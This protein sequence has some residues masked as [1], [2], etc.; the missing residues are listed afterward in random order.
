MRVVYSVG[1]TLGGGGLGV[2]AT[3][4]VRALYQKGYLA[5]AVVFSNRQNAAPSQYIKTTRM[6]P[7]KI[8]S[9]LPSRYYYPLKRKNLDRVT[10]GVLKKGGVDLFH[11][12]SSAS[13]TS[14]Q[15]C[16]ERGIVSF[17][18]NPG[19]HFQYVER[20][21]DR[22]YGEMGIRR[23]SQPEFFK[24]F[25]GQDDRYHAAELEAAAYILLESDFTAETFVAYGVPKEKIVV[26]PRG[27]DTARF[28]PPPRRERRPFRAI[29]VGAICVRKG[30]RYLLEA[31]SELGL[32]DAELVLAGTVR[33]EIK[34]TLNRHLGKSSNIKMMGFV[35]DPVRLYQEGSVF[36]F[37]SLSE[38]SA[39]VTY[40]AM[41]CGLPVV[42]TPNAGSVAR[43]GE[44]GFIV[45][46]RNKEILKEKILALYQNPEMREE[47]GERAGKHI[48]S[49]TWESHRQILIETY[50]RAY[51]KG[52]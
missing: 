29:F 43:D 1:T 40:E 18:E 23:K 31:W 30:V 39:K 45:P 28:V 2:D 26:I 25:F 20:L 5:K 34:P 3:E 10:R 16:R 22:E 17:L 19:P 52:L 41:A 27:V 50:E 24:R 13:L 21:M 49:Y 42:V 46:A 33:D 14:L 51:K 8:F 37:P 4:A 11:G 48:V 12:W 38:G 6:S 32:K 36:V 44:H 35:P 9:N 15:Y 7:V 47:M